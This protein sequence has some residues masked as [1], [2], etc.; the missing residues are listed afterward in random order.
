MARSAIFQAAS[1]ARVEI[2]IMS[3][4]EQMKKFPQIVVVLVLA[5]ASATQGKENAQSQL[6]DITVPEAEAAIAA[7]K[8]LVVI[9][10]RTPKEFAAGHLA[11]ATNIDYKG[12]DF[13]PQLEKLDRNKHYLIYCQ[14]GWRSGAAMKRFKKLGFTNV[15]HMKD[16]YLGW[17]KEH[18]AVKR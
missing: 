1:F 6:R 18:P 4:N 5:F 7:E 17:S 2:F 16:G 8:T 12:K 13:L 3:M 11:G 15:L 10:V 14:S 9:D